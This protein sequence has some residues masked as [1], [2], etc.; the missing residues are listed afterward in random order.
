MKVATH[1]SATGERGK[2]LLHSL[3]SVFSK[4]Q[5][6]TIRE[7]YEA[8]ARYFDLRVDKNLVLCHG[9]WRAKK[10]L[11]DVVMEMRRYV[12]DSVYV[13]VTI[14]HNY[15]AKAQQWQKEGDETTLTEE[16]RKEINATIIKYENSVRECIIEELNTEVEVD[17]PTINEAM[18]EKLMASND[19]EAKTALFV[20]DEIVTE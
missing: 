18:F 16:E 2:C 6:K 5:D 12:K 7:Q 13:A 14:E 19:W 9:L 10:T 4:C 1:N 3:F 11:Q 17:M 20:A 8:G 15:S